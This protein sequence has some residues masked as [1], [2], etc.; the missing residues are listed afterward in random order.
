MSFSLMIK[1]MHNLVIRINSMNPVKLLLL[2]LMISGCGLSNKA[3]NNYMKQWPQFRG[4]F[5][6]GTDVLKAGNTFELISKNPLDDV[7]R[8]TPAISGEMLFFRTQ[9]SLI[10]IGK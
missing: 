10:A 2:L 7:V 5:A 6:G 3:Q 1:E 9:H 4:P 8:A